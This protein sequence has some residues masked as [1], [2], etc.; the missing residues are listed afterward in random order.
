M[1][2]DLKLASP[3]CSYLKYVDDVTISEIVPARATS[4]LQS[5]L[6]ALNSW[7]DKNNMKLNPKK[8]EELTVHFWRHIEYFPLALAVNGNV[9]AYKVLGVTI[10]SNLKWDSHVN[11]IVGKASKRLH[12]LRVLKR[13]GAP[14]NDL[15]RVHIAL[16]MSVL[17]YSCPVWHSSLSVPLSER[18]ERMMQK[19]ALRI[20]FP[21]SHYEDALK[22]SSC[23]SLCARRELLCGKTFEKIKEP[24]SGL[25]HHMPPTRARAHGRSLHFN[26]RPSLMKCGTERFKKGFFPHICFKSHDLKLDIFQNY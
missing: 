3:R 10:Q 23:T 17:E 19:R 12:V 22:L 13:S 25:H 4:T 20:V 6:D 8:Y 16:I 5:E 7:A 1:I 9:E 2:N 26:D 15:R 14:P 24:G 11:E 18:I 21:A